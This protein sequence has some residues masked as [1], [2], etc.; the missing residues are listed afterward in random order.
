MIATRDFMS[1]VAH[2]SFITGRTGEEQVEMCPQRWDGSHKWERLPIRKV[3]GVGN[4]PL[5]IFSYRTLKSIFL[6]TANSSGSNVCDIG[7]Y[8]HYF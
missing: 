2:F 1:S 8:K 7:I 5:N 3:H 4:I 6:C